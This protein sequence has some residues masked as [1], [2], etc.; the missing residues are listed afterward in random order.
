MQIGVSKTLRLS[1]L[2]LHR[3]GIVPN[4]LALSKGTEYLQDF[5][6][7]VCMEKQLDKILWVQDNLLSSLA[8]ID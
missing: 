1:G 8:C 6:Q 5:S 3:P 4:D 2:K 7:D